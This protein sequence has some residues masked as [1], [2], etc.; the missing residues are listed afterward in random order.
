MI[1]VALLAASVAAELDRASVLKAVDDRVPQLSAASAK[2]AQAEAKLLSTLGNFDP[3][4]ESK[5]VRYGGIE[6][7]DITQTKLR[8]P[9]A[10][11]GDLS[12]AHNFGS[13]VFPGYDGDRQTK[14]RDGEIEINATLP[15]LEG[16]GM[17]ERRAEALVARAGVT[18]AEADFDLKR[19]EVRQKALMAYYKW[20]AAGA[21]RDIEQVL[22]EQTAERNAALDA[23]LQQGARARLDVLDNERAVLVRRNALVDAEREL[24]VAAQLLSLWYRD[25]NGRPIVPTDDQLSPIAASLAE[26]PTLE[27]DLERVVDRPDIRVVDAVVDAA[28]VERRRAFNLRM[29]QLDLVGEYI[30]PLGPGSGAGVEWFAGTDIKVPLLFRKGRGALGAAEANLQQLF[31]LRR[32]QIDA[33]RAEIRNAR[34]A[35]ETANQRVGFTDEAQ[36]LAAEVVDLERQR[37]AI[38]GGDVFDL[39][40]REGNLAKARK[41]AV[42]ARFDL[43]IALILRQAATAELANP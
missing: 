11:G 32:G 13:G 31:E 22:Y 8:T 16:L 41:D 4:V 14:G 33:A 36:D 10:F 42:D 20:L 30:E 27:E 23:E 37:F 5:L 9:F 29:P 3:V 38:G 12:V 39:L 2:I 28:N 18:L 34:L 19:I 1:L 21:K 7:R 35:I 24:G 26:L 43:Q 17:P 6:P 40:I 25:A 15:L